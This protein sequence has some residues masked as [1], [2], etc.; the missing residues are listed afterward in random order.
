MYGLAYCIVVS[1]DWMGVDIVDMV[2]FI[3]HFVVARIHHPA[4]TVE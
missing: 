2:V 4:V 3:S 1:R